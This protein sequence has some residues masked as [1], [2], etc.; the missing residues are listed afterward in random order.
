MN[1]VT[2]AGTIGNDVAIVRGLTGALVAVPVFA[3]PEGFVT[4]AIVRPRNIGAGVPVR[5]TGSAFGAIE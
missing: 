3:V 2:L 4:L 1:A 5:V